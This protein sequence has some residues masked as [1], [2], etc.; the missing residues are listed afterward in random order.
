MSKIDLLHMD[1]MDY[2]IA[3][4]YFGCDFVGIEID[5]DYYKAAVERFNNETRQEMLF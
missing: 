3:A 4:H 1:C 2:M 5:E